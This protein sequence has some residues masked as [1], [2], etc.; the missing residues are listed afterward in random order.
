MLSTK[1]FYVFVIYSCLSCKC[2]L[3]PQH[4]WATLFLFLLMKNCKKDGEEDCTEQ[5]TAVWSLDPS[6]IVSSWIFFFVSQKESTSSASHLTSVLQISVF[7]SLD[8]AF[9]M[10][11]PEKEINYCSNSSKLANP[12]PALQPSKALRVKFWFV[13]IP[14][15]GP[16]LLTLT[17]T[18]FWQSSLTKI[19]II[20]NIRYKVQY[21]LKMKIVQQIANLKKD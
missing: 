10:L 16:I 12:P 18:Q 17:L 1:I 19:L 11:F 8:I 4:W 9:N 20:H 2:P 13:I 7:S 14:I 6:N 3:A 21:L 5:G 15:S